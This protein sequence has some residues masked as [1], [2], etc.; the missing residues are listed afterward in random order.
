LCLRRHSEYLLFRTEIEKKKNEALFDKIVMTLSGREWT[1]SERDEDWGVPRRYTTQEL[2][3]I[4]LN[5]NLY[6]IN[7]CFKKNDPIVR[8]SEIANE[9]VQIFRELYNIYALAS[10]SKTSSQPNPRLGIFKSE[11]LVDEEEPEAKTDG[12]LLSETR[13]FLM[14]LETRKETHRIHL[15]GKNDQCTFKRKAVDLQLKPYRLAHNRKIVIIHSNKNINQT[16][17]I[18]LKNYD[19]FHKLTDLIARSLGLPKDF[20]KMMYV[21]PITDARYRKEEGYESILLNL[22]RFKHNPSK[23]FWTFAVSRELAYIRKHQLGYAFINQ[24]RAILMLA[25]DIK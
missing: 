14:S 11:T 12:T 6:W 21:D 7:A 25:N 19:E 24:L 5:P 9:I 23:F 1:I 3:G 18:V 20:L 8:T 15:P 13:K 22:A 4:L 16:S 2:K 17:R 10:D